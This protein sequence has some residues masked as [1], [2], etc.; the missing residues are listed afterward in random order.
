MTEYYGDPRTDTGCKYC[1]SCLNCT[2]PKC[3]EEVPHYERHEKYLERAKKVFDMREKGMDWP[4]IGKM[5][6]ISGRTAQRDLQICNSLL[7]VK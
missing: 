2:F 6:G 3:L 1:P 5:L 4:D 7:A